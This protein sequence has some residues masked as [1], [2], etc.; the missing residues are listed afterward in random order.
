MF[1]SSYFSNEQ[2]DIESV[3]CFFWIYEI[4]K[5]NNAETDVLFYGISKAKKISYD[6]CEYE[7]FWTMPPKR[8]FLDLNIW[9]RIENE[10][11]FAAIPKGL[12]T[13]IK[14]HVINGYIFSK[15]WRFYISS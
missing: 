14:T 6:I 7:I 5:S 11:Y 4:D 10:I 8:G 12:V 1:M 3:P 9:A 15:L 13:K 2:L